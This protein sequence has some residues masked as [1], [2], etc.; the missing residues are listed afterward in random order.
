MCVAQATTA[1]VDTGAMDGEN[2]RRPQPFELHTR[3]MC[4]HLQVKA[5]VISPL[6]DSEDAYACLFSGVSQGGG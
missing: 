1:L 3:M 4:R 5:I 2:E 6:G